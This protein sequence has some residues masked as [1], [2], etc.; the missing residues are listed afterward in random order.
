MSLEILDGATEKLDHDEHG[1]NVGHKE[2]K[3]LGNGSSLENDPD[4]PEQAGN[5]EDENQD[6]HGDQ[7]LDNEVY[8]LVEHDDDF[9]GFFTASSPFGV[10]PIHLADHFREAFPFFSLLGPSVLSLTT[11]KVLEFSS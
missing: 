5:T 4:I 11:L 8:Y 3:T 6:D 2:I 10:I 7:E 1:Q 9:P